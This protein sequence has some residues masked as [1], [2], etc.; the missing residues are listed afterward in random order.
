MVAKDLPGM[1][2]TEESEETLGG[3]QS[4]ALGEQFTEIFAK[5]REN[6]ELLINLLD[7]YDFKVRYPT[8]KL[9][10]NLLMNR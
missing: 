3:P 9:L 7:E 10:T 2:P 4:S 1:L 5:R 8:V 6:I